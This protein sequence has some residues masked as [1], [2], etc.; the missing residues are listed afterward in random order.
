MNKINEY[1]RQ[2]VFSVNR[3]EVSFEPYGGAN[4]QNPD[5]E[6]HI[7]DSWEIKY[8]CASK[9]LV[10]IPPFTIHNSTLPASEVINFGFESKEDLF[11]GSNHGLFKARKLSIDAFKIFNK[12]IIDY[13]LLFK[14]ILE[15]LNY[16]D[17]CR[18]SALAFLNAL[19]IA[20]EN[21]PQPE[22]VQPKAKIQQMINFIARNYYRNNFSIT[23]IAGE[24]NLCSNYASGMFKKNTGIKLIEFIHSYRLDKAKL[25]LET[26]NYSVKEVA[27]LCGWNSPF[28]FS[29][30]FKKRYGFSPNKVNLP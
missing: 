29:N 30:C 20:F 5:G 25:L 7:H 12:L 6:K 28:Y 24:V 26:G 15:N 19:I 4:Y 14:N 3:G 13:S 18:G 16:P 11:I 9:T 1:L 17:Y 10:F 23:D 22:I 21:S 27:S 8:Y 2:I